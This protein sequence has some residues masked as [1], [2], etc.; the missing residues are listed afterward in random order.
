M[1]NK[2][3]NKYF[4]K[5]FAKILHAYQYDI[6]TGDIVAG[7]IKYK[8]YDG[9][10]VNIGDQIA[11][12]LPF[13][14][15]QLNNNHINA[16]NHYLLYITRDFFLMTHHMAKKQS[17][18]SIKRLE[19]MRAWKRIKQVYLEDIIF[20]LPIKYINKGGII[21]NIEGL[22][23]FIPNS[24]TYNLNLTNVGVDIVCK[25]SLINENKNEIIL[26]QKS[27]LLQISKHKFRLGE[28]TYGIIANIQT[29]GIFI[30]IYGILGL[31]HI[32]E[33]SSQYIS[34]IYN[35]FRIGYLIKIKIIHINTIQG[36]LSVST[37]NLLKNTIQVLI[38]RQ[39]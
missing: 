32:S 25:L 16:V 8:E 34:N 15:I 35:I 9:F 39:Q 17:I 30:D 21:I 6:T 33:I 29:Y 19:Y 7:I 14:E 23:G 1:N 20:R 2:Y 22:H 12:S 24:Y 28:I 13:E 5:N 18:L 11:G 4:R 3:I 36:R 10:L 38:L 26:S 27:A 37:K 31:L